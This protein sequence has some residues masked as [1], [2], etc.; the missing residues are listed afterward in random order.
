MDFIC[1]NVNEYMKFNNLFWNS[2]SKP[3]NILVSISFL[4]IKAHD[5]NK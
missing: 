4:K 3:D 2:L 1:K 5:F